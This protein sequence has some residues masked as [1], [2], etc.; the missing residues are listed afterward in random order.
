MSLTKKRGNKKMLQSN[1]KKLLLA[2]SFLAATSAANAGYEIKLSDQ[3]KITFGGYIKV[4][5]RYVNGDV[6]YRDFWIGTGG[7]LSESASQ[8]RIN[9]NE[10]RFNTKYVH[11]DVM[12][13]LELDFLN[14]S[15]G[16]Q[17][18]SNSASPRIRHAF[19]KYKNITAG[20]TWTTF[21][22]TSAIPETADFA[23]ATVGLA[24]IRQGQFRYTSGNFQVSIENPETW[25]GDPTN[26]NTPDVI[27]K[28][29]FAGDWGSISIAGLARNLTTVSGKSTNSFGASIAGRIK[30]GGKDDLRFQVHNGELGRYV[31]VAVAKGVIGEEVESMTAYLAAYRHFWNETMRTTVL[32]GRAKA[33]LS[34][35]DRRQWSINVF[36]N[37]TKQLAFGAEIGNFSMNDKNVDSDYI[38]FSLQYTL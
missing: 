26:D 14:S 23:G 17:I 37:L 22:N 15:Q 38:Q 21:M 20:Q 31:G 4:D 5:G 16:N 29:N 36:D 18:I 3:D 11:G 1:Y 32:Y 24:F 28:Y 13:Y 25:G 27:A 2:S 34:G 30:T 8:F 7:V 9:A 6:A 35:A 10:T 19:I 12:G 33:D